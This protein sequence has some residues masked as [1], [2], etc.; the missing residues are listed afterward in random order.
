MHF[1]KVRIWI[2]VIALGPL[3]N[4]GLA[5]AATTSFDLRYAAE[6]KLTGDWDMVARAGDVNGDDFPDLLVSECSSNYSVSTVVLGRLPNGRFNIEDD[7]LRTY[8]I[9]GGSPDDGACWIAPAGD[10]NGDGLDDIMIGAP[11]ADHNGAHSGTTYLLFGSESPRDVRLEEFDQNRQGDMGFRIEGPE[12]L[13]RI[14]QE[15]SAIGDINQDGLDDVVVGSWTGTSYVVFGKRTTDPVDLRTF[16]MNVQGLAGYR[17]E[18]RGADRSDN[19]E[20]SGAGDV[21]GDGADDLLIGVTPRILK[22]AGTAYVV[23]GKSDPLPVD[24]RDQTFQGFRIKGVRRGDATGWSLSAAGDANADGKNDVV[25]GAPGKYSEQGGTGS[26]WVVFGKTGLDTVDLASLGKR[27][28][29]IKGEDDRDRAGYS[30]ADVGDVNSD[31]K[32]DVIVGAPLASARGRST[33][34]SV[35]VVYGKSSSTRVTLSNMRSHGYRMD[36]GRSGDLAGYKVDAM[37]D[38]NEFSDLLVGG[39]K[40]Y[41]AG[42]NR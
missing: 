12:E 28:Y 30:V 2:L 40:A 32:D 21:N 18:T 5:Q 41:V 16:D 9:Y 1:Q 8:H 42:V 23:F 31:G 24:A 10:I 22:S 27:G 38:E 11:A 34:G 3:A 19:Y 7:Q 6:F 20:V 25:I 33:C 39:S 13:S 35:N 4:M 14:G 26:A 37:G 17:V 29:Q 15:M 36:G